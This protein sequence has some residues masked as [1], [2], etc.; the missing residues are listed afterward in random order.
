MHKFDVFAIDYRQA[1]HDLEIGAFSEYASYKC[2]LLKNS[3]NIGRMP[4]HHL[5]KA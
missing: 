4:S 2:F 5:G 1:N 3:N